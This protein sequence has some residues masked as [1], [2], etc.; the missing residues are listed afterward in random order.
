MFSKKDF[1]ANA[2]LSYVRM[3]LGLVS[4]I[5]LAPSAFVMWFFVFG[6]GDVFWDV[7][8]IA[9][10]LFILSM[11]MAEIICGHAKRLNGLALISLIPTVV[12]IVCR[13]AFFKESAGPPFLYIQL[14]FLFL[15]IIFILEFCL[16]VEVWL[17]RK[18]R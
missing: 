8:I 12:L 18:S 4:L 7:F 1:L 17:R 5:L 11:S 9:W 3:A 15:K 2:V 6:K 14:Q 13:L 10:L 16:F